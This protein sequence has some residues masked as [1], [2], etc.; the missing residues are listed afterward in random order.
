MVDELPAV[1]ERQLQISQVGEQRVLP[2][3]KRVQCLLK[4][5]ALVLEALG[6]V[7]QATGRE[8]CGNVLGCG[9]LGPRGRLR[10]LSVG[11]LQRRVWG[12]LGLHDAPH[13]N[14]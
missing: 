6:V 4:G 1:A 2:R 12:L 7:L 13:A 11:R 14:F 8:H 9:L 10:N 5:V 3:R